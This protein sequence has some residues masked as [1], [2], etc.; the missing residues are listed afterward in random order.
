MLLILCILRDRDVHNVKHT[1]SLEDM[2]KEK[3]FE[4][5]LTLF[6]HIQETNNRWRNNFKYFMDE[7]KN[8]NSQSWLVAMD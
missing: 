7:V 6:V 3:S 8:V 4:S 2:V 5:D 1:D